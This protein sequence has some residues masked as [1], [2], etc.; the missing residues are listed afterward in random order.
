MDSFSG[1]LA[2]HPVVRCVAGMGAALDDVEGVGPLGMMVG[3]KEAVLLDPA[4]R[5][6]GRVE[7]GGPGGC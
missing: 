4:D 6:G 7:A 3:E 1:P 2:P 5:T